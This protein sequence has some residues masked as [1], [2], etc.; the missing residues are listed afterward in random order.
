[1]LKEK[2]RTFSLLISLFTF[3]LILSCK[4]GTVNSTKT[5]TAVDSAY[6]DET[7]E[8]FSSDSSGLNIFNVTFY[9]RNDLTDVFISISDIYTDSLSISPEFFKNQEKIK[10]ENRIYIELDADYRKKML[11]ALRLTENDTLYIFNYE[12][13]SVQKTPLSK[14]KSVAYLSYYVGQDD[15]IDANSYMLG[16]QVEAQRKWENIYQKYDNS[17]AYFGNKN[18]FVENQLVPVSWKKIQPTTLTNKLFKDSNN[19]IG[20]LHE[21]KNTNLTYYLQDFS[22]EE[23]IIRRN[24]VVVDDANKIFFEQS[25]DTNFEGREFTELRGI[26]TDGADIIYSQWTGNLF[27]N[28]PPVIF[29][30]TSESFGCSSISLMDKKLSEIPI[31]CDNRH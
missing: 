14:L 18:P 9:D 30:F 16:F 3:L 19:K 27:K 8:E 21:F 6:V 15:N 1:M 28:K 10:F 5:N 26:I 29:G 11:T 17:I 31:N 4:D 13:A 25:F 7:N 12:S 24:L 2:H 22:S 20:I 23:R